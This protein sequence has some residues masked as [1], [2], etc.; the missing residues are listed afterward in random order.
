MN[1]LNIISVPLYEFVADEQLTDAVLSDVKNLDFKKSNL[2]NNTSSNNFYYHPKLFE[3]FDKCLSEL[4]DKLQIHPIIELPIISC[5]VNKNSKFQYH[6][7][8]NHSNSII[9]GIFYLTTHES[10]DTV[11][12]IPDPWYDRINNPTILVTTNN[13]SS[14][15]QVSPRIIGKN[16]PVKGK[17]ILFPS[18]INH[19]VLPLTETGVRYT[20]AFNTFFSGVSGNSE[21]PTYLNLTAKSVK[22]RFEENNK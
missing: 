13:S 19:K 20:I 2:G 10:G 5:W 11:F 3:F 16:K 15:N 21:S 9:S 6:H 4:K 12:T 1:T 7:Y 18:H 17:L 14:Y 22:E 8:H